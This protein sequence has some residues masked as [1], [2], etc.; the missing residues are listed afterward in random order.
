MIRE[1]DLRIDLYRTAGAA[2][3]P[4]NSCSV[5]ITHMQSGISGTGTD[6]VTASAYKARDTALRELLPKLRAAGYG[7]D[8]EPS[9]TPKSMAQAFQEAAWELDQREEE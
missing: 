7:W 2:G 8:F 1:Q 6:D 4:G 3:C 9:A 5:R